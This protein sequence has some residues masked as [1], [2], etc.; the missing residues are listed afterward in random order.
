MICVWSRRVHARRITTPP[1]P[2]PSLR[3]SDHREGAAGLCGVPTRVLPCSLH[4]T[5]QRVRSPL[6][7]PLASRRSRG[8]SSLS[9]LSRRSWCVCLWAAAKVRAAVCAGHG[10]RLVSLPPRLCCACDHVRLPH[11]LAPHLQI[12]AI[13]EALQEKEGIDVKQIR[14]IHSG[15]QLCVVWRGGAAA[16]LVSRAL[17]APASTALARRSSC[18]AQPMLMPRPFLCSEDGQTIEASKIEAGATI[19]MVLSLRGG[20][21]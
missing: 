6:S 21:A 3:A 7:L 17:S 10:V 15:K 8:A 5:P 1:L 4:T 2:R 11:A 9:T 20:A 19:H 13:K 12:S 16:A 14:L 18:D